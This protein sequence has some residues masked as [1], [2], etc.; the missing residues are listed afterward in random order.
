[1]VAHEF[2]FQAADSAGAFGD[3]GVDATDAVITLETVWDG[4]VAGYS[5]DAVGGNFS[6]VTFLIH[7]AGSAVA[8][9]AIAPGAVAVATG[10]YG[11]TVVE[12]SAGDSLK[13]EVDALTT[14]R[15]CVVTLYVIYDVGE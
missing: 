3:R 10:T 9:S 12:F 11:E 15:D 4:F 5:V 2:G 6:G 8:A 1:M 13:V 14:F 7:V